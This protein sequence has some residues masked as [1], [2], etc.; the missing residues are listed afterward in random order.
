[1]HG[2]FGDASVFIVL[3]IGVIALISGAIAGW[4]AWISLRGLRRSMKDLERT[5]E[6]VGGKL[7]LI[8]SQLTRRCEELEGRIAGLELAQEGEGVGLIELED[9]EEPLRQPVQPEEPVVE[10]SVQAVGEPLSQEGREALSA[11]E[12]AP[13]L[14]HPLRD[15]PPG[16]LGKVLP[17]PPQEWGTWFEENVG[18]RW[19]TWAGALALF[20]SAAFFLKHAFENQW[21]GP[22]GRVILGIAAGILLLIAGDYHLRKG[23]RALGQGL[24]GGGLAILYV[25]LF[26][27]FSFYRLM[28]QIPAFTAMVVVTAA[29]MAFAILHDAPPLAFLAVLGGFLTPIMVSTGEV[30]R[31]PLFAYL[32]VLDLGVLGAAVFKRWRRLDILAFVGTW[33]FYGVWFVD[34][35]PF[36]TVTPALLWIACFYLIFLLI[37]FVYQLRTGTETPVERFLMALANAVVA[38]CFAYRLLRQDYQFVLGFVALSMSACY[39]A[40]AVLCRSRT[41]KDAKTLFAFVSLSVVFLTLAVPLHLKVHGITMAWAVEGPVLVY[42][43]YAYRYRPVR[44]AGAL[45]VA[46]AV[47]R[48]LSAHWPL[49]VGLYVPFIN[50]SFLSAMTVPLGAA[51]YA[52]VHS[53]FSA[54]ETPLDRYGKIGAAL[55]AG[56]LAL[57]I[58]HSECHGW[59][60][61]IAP[62]LKMQPQYLAHS[63][64]PIIWAIGAIGFLLGSFLVRSR[65]SFY[66][67]LVALACGIVLSMISFGVS[68][69]PNYTLVLN[70]RFFAG[71][72]V[73][74]AIF[75]F[76]SVPKKYCHFQSKSDRYAAKGVLIAAALFPLV[77]LSAEVVTYCQE[78]IRG[79]Q[80]RRWLSQ[81][82]L[83]IV[84]GLYAVAALV[85]GFRRNIRELRIGA[86]VLLGVTGIKLVLVDMAWV[87]Q[88]YRVISFVVIGLIMML[89]S[90]LYHRLEKRLKDPFIEQPLRTDRDTEQ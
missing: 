8:Q 75:A 72:S 31:D 70:V 61:Q 64:S 49:H 32:T 20:F 36:S 55:L 29:G 9:L 2:L 89:A 11:G 67:G 19:M 25:S 90:Y 85:V 30:V 69:G 59:L 66:G 5:A 47:L 77:L 62:D 73:A 41:P 14:T 71:L 74:A 37:P 10:P 48:L 86:L 79:Y 39:L 22:S 34:T 46:L 68:A 16:I 56:F 81:M 18:K 87:Q 44:I 78:T 17:E 57:V 23:M 63:V 12:A 45:V 50:R 27:A 38:F 6:E 24:L 43:G 13:A 80:R 21:I 40:M 65:A 28:P 82:S 53:R 84:W 35:L 52:V 1:M 88:I 60:L 58:V 83:S 7:A 15:E 54:I 51:A 42:L 33:F 76:H 3:V 26:A 4:I